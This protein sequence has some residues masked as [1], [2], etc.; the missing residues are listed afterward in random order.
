MYGKSWRVCVAM[1]VFALVALCS[2]QAQDGKPTDEGNA[3]EFKGK[4]FDLKEK[5]K[6]SII[7]T[8][9]AKKEVTV[10]VKSK[11]KSDVNLFIYTTPKKGKKALLH[12]DDSPGPDCEITF[13]P[14]KGGKLTLVVVNKGP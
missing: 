1:V 5:G 7:L 13:T 10:L 3:S 9:D 12:K 2:A 8:F 4:T 6:A 11:G 14:K